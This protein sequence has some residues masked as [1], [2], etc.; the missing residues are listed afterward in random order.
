MRSP[1]L[2]R[3]V[4]LIY[5]AAALACWWLDWRAG[6]GYLIGFSVGGLVVVSWMWQERR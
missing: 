2:N 6:I 1:V 5:S 3:L 4:M